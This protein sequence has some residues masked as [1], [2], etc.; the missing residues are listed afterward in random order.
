MSGKELPTAKE[1]IGEG[2]VFWSD[3]GKQI[4]IFG[5]TTTLRGPVAVLERVAMRVL[6]LVDGHGGYAQEADTTCKRCEAVR[7]ARRLAQG[8]FTIS[9]RL[10]DAFAKY[11]VLGFKVGKVWLSQVHIDLLEGTKGWDP[12]H[13]RAVRETGLRGLLWGAQVYVSD[14]LPPNHVAILPD[15]FDGTLVDGAGSMPL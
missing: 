9:S 5:E 15:G 14:V 1:P 3:E 13:Q 11:E 4:R 2:E 10:A 6:H 7:R 8:D 12:V